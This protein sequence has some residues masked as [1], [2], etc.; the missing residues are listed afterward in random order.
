M[1]GIP[2]KP[3]VADNP[4]ADHPGDWQWLPALFS[5][6]QLYL[7]DARFGLPIAG[8]DGKG[9]ATLQQAIQ[10]DSILRKLDLDGDPY[11][12]TSELLKGANAFIVADPFE[13]SRRAA[14]VEANLTGEDHLVLSVQPTELA[15]Q[16]K[17]VPGIH[18]VA[19]W[20]V[21]FRT[22]L[23]Q[24]TLGNRPATA[25]PSR[26]SRSPSARLWKAR[27]R[28]FQGRRKEPTEPG[29]D[30][31]NDHQEAVRLYMSKSVRLP[32]SEIAASPS[33][34]KQRI[35]LAQN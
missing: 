32:D 23:G 10:D 14:L 1:L 25:K 22:L 30:T 31:I 28:H 21:P 15:E 13:L 29:G 18:G 17:S 27:T 5:G 12:L 24:L 3:A 34:D 4:A 16:L 8:P 20:D 35:D 11:P 9:V 2:P 6:G 26:S 7:F 33:S 19:L